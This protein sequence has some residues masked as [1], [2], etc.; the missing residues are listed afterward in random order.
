MT[1]FRPLLL[2]LL[3]A[4]V[5]IGAWQSGL[6]KNSTHTYSAVGRYSVYQT[7]D[8]IRHRT[9]NAFGNIEELLPANR[10]NGRI[11]VSSDGHQ[12]IIL[13]S[14]GAG[15]RIRVTSEAPL[16]NEQLA[17]VQQCS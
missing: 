8:C 10:D 1:R 2:T 6:W 14:V 15:T 7:R 13:P 11:L 5:G 17:A 3:L 12:I 4:G 16:S 9:V